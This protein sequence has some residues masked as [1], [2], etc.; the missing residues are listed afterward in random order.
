MH[1][2]PLPHIFKNSTTFHNF[3]PSYHY[4]RV[5]S[6]R[7]RVPPNYIHVRKCNA[8]WREKLWAKFLGNDRTHKLL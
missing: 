4:D 1:L 6:K 8:R 5:S 7:E 3:S 2:L